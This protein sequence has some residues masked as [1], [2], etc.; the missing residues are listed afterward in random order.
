MFMCPGKNVKKKG[1]LDCIVKLQEQFQK[2]FADIKEE[3]S[4]K[5]KEVHPTRVSHP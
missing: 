2:D 1:Q 4:L 3:S 5:T